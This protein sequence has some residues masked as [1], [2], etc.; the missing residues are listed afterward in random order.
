M[1]FLIRSFVPLCL[2][3]LTHSTANADE[4]PTKYEAYIGAQ[5]LGAFE[6]FSESSPAFP[7]DDSVGFGFKFGVRMDAGSDLFDFAVET[8]L[9]TYSSTD[10]NHAFGFTGVPGQTF[11]EIESTIML[12][13][14]LSLTVIDGGRVEPYAYGGFGALQ[15]KT[16][17]AFT[18]TELASA[19][20]F[21]VE[22]G[23]GIEVAI[24]NN[25]SVF[26]EFGYLTTPKDLDDAPFA[27]IAIGFNVGFGTK[28]SSS[29]GDS[30]ARKR[31]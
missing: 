11:R 17:E 21:A 19:T 7:V 15:I 14:K 22:F 6:D 3:S 26:G 4:L 18:R 31:T 23:G 13:S 9:N 8:N 12:R 24:K 10:F 1:K 2:L 28:D 29:T 20:A 16:R 25:A 5:I 30:R 27:I